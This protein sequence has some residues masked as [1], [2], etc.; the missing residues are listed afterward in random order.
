MHHI[1]I[2]VVTVNVD[3]VSHPTLILYYHASML[4]LPTSLI[5]CGTLV[6]TG[7]IL[8]RLECNWLLWR[9]ERNKFICSKKWRGEGFKNVI[10][11][12]VSIIH[13]E[14]AKYDPIRFM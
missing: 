7:V 5:S 11:H 6:A 13:D 12:V 10:Y 4:T 2:I 3:F 1:A 8:G 9:W 14:H